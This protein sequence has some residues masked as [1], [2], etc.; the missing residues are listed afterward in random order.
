MMTPPV[1]VVLFVICGMTG[2]KMGE[3]V[4]HCMPFIVSQYALLLLCLFFPP[5]VTWL[6]KLVGY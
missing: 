6:P 3:L 4:R 5:L 2:I 1:G